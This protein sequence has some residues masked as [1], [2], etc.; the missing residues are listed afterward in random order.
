MGRLVR[1]LVQGRRRSLS[2]EQQARCF[3][4]LQRAGAEPCAIAG[5]GI[6]LAL[7]RRIAEMCGRRSWP[8]QQT[9]PGQPMLGACCINSPPHGDTP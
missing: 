1:R 7:N 8:G 6:G 2:P 3:Q 5:W 9:R 4:P